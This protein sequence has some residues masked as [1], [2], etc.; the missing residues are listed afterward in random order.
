MKRFLLM[1]ML[2][3]AAFMSEGQLVVSGSLGLTTMTNK[4]DGDKQVQSFSFEVAPSIGYVFGDWEFGLLFEY[5][6]DKT[7]TFADDKTVSEAAYAVGPYAYYCFAN[8][9]KIILGA[10]ANSMF[11]FA[12]GEHS[13]NLQLL[14][15][16]TYEINDRWDIDFFSDILSVN[17]LWTKTDD[18]NRTISHFNVLSNSGKLFG[19]GLTFKF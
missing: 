16:A 7:T 12:D 19:I 17:Y 1:T 15:V 9:G 14:P 4:L 11:G 6:H 13:V 10:E 8:I 5:S 18:D 3:S 2:L